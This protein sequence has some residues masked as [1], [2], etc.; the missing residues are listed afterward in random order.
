MSYSASLPA[1]LSMRNARLNSGLLTTPLW[2]TSHLVGS[3][4]GGGRRVA[5]GMA[6]VVAVGVVVGMGQTTQGTGPTA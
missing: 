6:V 5:V 3:G 1:I 2:S 4:A